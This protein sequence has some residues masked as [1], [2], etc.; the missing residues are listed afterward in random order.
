MYLVTGVA[1][2]GEG[3]DSG[4]ALLPPA[5]VEVVE[6]V[7]AFSPRRTPAALNPIVAIWVWKPIRIWREVKAKVVDLCRVRVHGIRELCYE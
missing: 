3:A 1:D 6:P 7:A 2:H 4:E 5:L